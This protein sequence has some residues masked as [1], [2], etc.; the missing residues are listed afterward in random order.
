MKRRLFLIGNS[1]LQNSVFTEYVVRTIATEGPLNSIE[2][3][4]NADR[5]FNTE[6][7]QRISTQE[8]IYIVT[9]TKTFTLVGKLIATLTQDNL[10][11]KE[12]LLIP[13]QCNNYTKNSYILEV[14]GAHLNILQVTESE[15]LPTLLLKQKEQGATLHVFEHTVKEVITF[16]TP[17]AQQFGVTLSFSQVVQGWVHVDVR[18]TPF[19]ALGKFM[20]K[21][22]QEQTQQIIIAKDLVTHIIEKLLEHKKK[23]TLAESCTGGLL[24]YYFTSHA[25]VSSVF[26]GSLVTYSNILKENWIAVENSTL[27]TYGAVSEPVVQEMCEGARSIANADYALAISGVA[28][29]DGGT[30]E[31]PVGTVV[32]GVSSEKGTEVKRHFFAGDRKYIQEQ[33]ALTALK[34]LVLGDK[35]VF[36]TN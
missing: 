11:L 20:S 25:G 2:F 26:E 35:E 23:I 7:E 18:S 36:F 5:D 29:P 16:L 15:T 24:A 12:N 27:V 34:V 10:V 30:V 14:E 19:G 4:D 22:Q 13:S 6:L 31:K 28:G 9:N 1:F 8:H 3:F 32:I 33:S 21:A 17:L